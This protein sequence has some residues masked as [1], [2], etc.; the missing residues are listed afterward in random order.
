MPPDPDRWSSAS[1]L[2]LY[3][4]V[5]GCWYTSSTF[6]CIRAVTSG[7]HLVA[8]FLIRH[9]RGRPGASTEGCALVR[10]SGAAGRLAWPVLLILQKA[11]CARRASGGAPMGNPPQSSARSDR[12]GALLKHTTAKE[13]LPVQVFIPAGMVHKQHRPRRLSTRI[14]D[15]RMHKIS[16]SKGAPPA[17][18]RRLVT[19]EIIFPVW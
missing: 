4:G 17:T 11:C 13:R 5:H 16:S 1:P 10:L 12:G 14:H 6:C 2:V 8:D 7:V 19:E 9:R 15:R 18:H 3:M